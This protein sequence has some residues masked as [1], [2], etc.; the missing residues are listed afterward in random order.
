VILNKSPIYFISRYFF[1]FT[2]QKLAFVIGQQRSV[3]IIHALSGGPVPLK[4]NLPH[5][6]R[7]SYTVFAKERRKKNAKFSLLLCVAWATLCFACCLSL[8]CLAAWSH[9]NVYCVFVGVCDKE[10]RRMVQTRRLF[11]S[12]FKRMAR[13]VVL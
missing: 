8:L 1:T 6:Y 10:Y 5:V 7:A 4:D 12:F 11:T 3:V 13:F 9:R 2:A